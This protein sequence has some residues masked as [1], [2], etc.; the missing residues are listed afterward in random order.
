MSPEAGDDGAR[1]A[2]VYSPDFGI[3]ALYQIVAFFWPG[4]H[5][6]QG[7][8]AFAPGQLRSEHVGQHGSLQAGGVICRLLNR[9]RAGRNS[10]GGAVLLSG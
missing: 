6:W 7:G 2:A 1:L 8:L 10:G 4:L 5:F 9:L 3:A